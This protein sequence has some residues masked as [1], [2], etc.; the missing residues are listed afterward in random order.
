MPETNESNPSPCA[1]F[2]E[3]ILDDL[4]GS[5][6]AANRQKLD[7]HLGGCA[8]CRNFG[9]QQRILDTALSSNLRH[10]ALP[11]NFKRAMLQRAQMELSQ[12]IT[13]RPVLSADEE[14]G[15]E[16]FQDYVRRQFWRSIGIR[17]LDWAGFGAVAL[18]SAIALSDLAPQIPMRLA[19]L[20]MERFASI[21]AF[22]VAAM[23]LGA[24]LAIAFKEL[25][26]TVSE[27]F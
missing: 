6:D 14:Y 25:R 2:E 10:A 19:S 16:N 12:Q 21:V 11:T 4:D 5:L 23:V 9:E 27:W 26:Q 20:P 18:T 17:A 15:V 8:S 22:P 3:S 13:G 7:A 1:D 24:G